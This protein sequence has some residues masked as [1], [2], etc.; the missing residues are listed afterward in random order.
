MSVEVKNVMNGTYGELWLDGEKCGEVDG[1][2]AKIAY[3]RDDIQLC[4]QLEVDSKLVSSK[5][6]GSIKAY[7]IYSRF[8]TTIAEKAKSGKD[9]RFTIISK[10]NDPDALGTERIALQNCVFDDVTLVDWEKGKSGSIDTNFR[11]TKYKLL[12]TV[13]AD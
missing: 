10:L 8:I 3:T 12:D 5:G 2:S 4:G 11:F 7:K 1:C 13:E 9:P 6:T